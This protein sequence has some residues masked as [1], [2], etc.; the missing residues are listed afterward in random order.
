MTGDLDRLFGTA[1]RLLRAG[2]WVEARQRI[3][4]AL[5][6]APDWPA[7]LREAGG[8]ALRLAGPGRANICLRR[9]VCRSP[10]DSRCWILLA[11]A[12]YAA[13]EQKMAS[14]AARRAAILAP[15]RRDAWSFL[16]A[17]AASDGEDGRALVHLGRSRSIGPLSIVDLQVALHA[18]LSIGLLSRA[19]DIAR[20]ILTRVPADPTAMAALGRVWH[21]RRHPES[22]W[23]YVRRV[24]LI[25]VG[26]P[27]TLTAM[28][29]AALVAGGLDLAAWLARRAIV[30]GAGSGEAYLDLARPLWRLERGEAAVRAI[31]RAMMIDAAMALRGR[32]LRL[33]VTKSE[34]AAAFQ[35]NSV[36]T[37]V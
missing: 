21:R 36:N 9:A 24:G 4:V 22:T 13:R 29:R 23:R 3:D 7:G 34:F 16:A 35:R 31:D 20:M 10:D 27:R 26:D 32:I 18:C 2:N 6:A 17:D 8:L 14:A 12:G 5:T 19:T 25:R 15:A 28:S 37:P 30:A 11:R 33:T 1:D